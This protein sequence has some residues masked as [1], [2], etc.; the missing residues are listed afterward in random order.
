MTVT[1]EQTATENILEIHISG[2]I[3]RPDYDRFVPQIEQR[4]A[5]N[6]KLRLLVVME[7]FHGL[8][9]GALWQDLKFEWNHFDDFERIAFVAD[10]SWEKTLATIKGLQNLATIRFFTPDQIEQ[11]RQWIQQD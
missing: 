2:K 4:I 9:A 3:G 11:A 7:D 6:G 1:L 5:E 8:D 10:T